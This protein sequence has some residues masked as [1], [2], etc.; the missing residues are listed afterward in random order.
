MGIGA[1]V[2]GEG[3]SSSR[4]PGRRQIHPDLRHQNTALTC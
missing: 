2:K 1:H 4:A 3:R